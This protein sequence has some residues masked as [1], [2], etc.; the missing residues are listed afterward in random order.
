MKYRLTA[1][2]DLKGN[3]GQFRRV[4]TLFELFGDRG[5]TLG[6][7]ALTPESSVNW[8]LGVVFELQP[9]VAVNRLFLEYAYFSSDAEDLIV[10]VQNSQ[11]TAQPSILVR[12]RF[13]AMR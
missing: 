12:H 3:I 11:A 6:N 8:D 9:K 5:T 4:P 1:F 7:P 10:F 13:A 2:L